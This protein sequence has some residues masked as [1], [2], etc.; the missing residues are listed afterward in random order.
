MQLSKTL[1]QN[2]LKK[3]EDVALCSIPSAT[4]KELVTKDH[5]HDIMLYIN[6]MMMMI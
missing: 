2:K 1:P 3:D 5:N 6:A 4:K